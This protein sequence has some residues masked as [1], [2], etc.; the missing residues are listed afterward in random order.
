MAIKRSSKIDMG[1]SN[2]SQTDLIFLLLLFLMMT[3]LFCMLMTLVPQVR[4]CVTE[5]QWKY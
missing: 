4:V 5:R 3:T 1:G 2:S